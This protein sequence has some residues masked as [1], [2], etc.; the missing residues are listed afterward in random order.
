MAR[1][2]GPTPKS[3]ASQTKALEE[4]RTGGGGETAVPVTQDPSGP[5]ISPTVNTGASPVTQPQGV[6]LTDKPQDNH[7]SET[8]KPDPNLKTVR[9]YPPPVTFDEACDAIARNVKKFTEAGMGGKDAGEL[10]LQVWQHHRYV[11]R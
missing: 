7:E 6:T 2:T 9:S 11:S 10:A 5:G 4:A 3:E 8:D 1:H